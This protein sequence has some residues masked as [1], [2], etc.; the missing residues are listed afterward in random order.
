VSV[1]G[2]QLARELV[3]TLPSG[4]PGL[5][6]PWTDACVRDLTPKTAPHERLRRL[7]SH[8]DC[9][10]RLILVGEAPGYQGCS[11]SGIAFTSERLLGEGV[12]PRLPSENTRLTDRSRPFSEP[13]STI[14]WG[15]LH[16]PGPA[17]DTVL[18]NAVMLHPHRPDAPQSNR[19]PR[20]DELALGQP[21]LHLLRQRFPNARWVAVGKKASLALQEAGLDDHVPVRH[22]ANGGA[23]CLRE[24]MHAL[25]PSLGTRR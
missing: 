1:D 16:D 9:A 4:L 12:I 25:R 2:V 18:W 15:V 10:A 21:A 13:S 11:Y 7:G 23:R 19:T 22:P 24:A 8:L 20:A 14:V 3:A 5:F 6:N 17:A